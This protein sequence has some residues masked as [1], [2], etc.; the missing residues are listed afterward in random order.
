[1]SPGR[2]KIAIAALNSGATQYFERRTDAGS[3]SP[4][5]RDAINHALFLRADLSILEKRA[6][7]LE[8]LSR[9]ALDFVGMED[10]DDV[11]AYIGEKVRELVPEALVAVT[12]FDPETRFFTIRAF[13]TPPG[14]QRVFEEEL[15]SGLVG[16]HFPLDVFPSSATVLECQTVSES[17]SALYILLYHTVPEEVCDRIDAR[18]GPG[19]AFSLGFQCRKG[20]YGS[21]CLR[22]IGTSGFENRDLVR[23]FVGQASV[24]LLRRQA[25]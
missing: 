24:A 4:D 3:T 13:A 1:M 16:W 9:T 19:R 5:L 25:R 8:F 21:V 14:T 6:E 10:E 7:H 12:S 17:P 23:A 22:L 18:L 20:V 15:G 2:E 11:Y